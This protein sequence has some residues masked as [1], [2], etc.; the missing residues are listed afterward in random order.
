MTIDLYY[1]PASTPCRSVRMVAQGLG[2][3]LNLKLVDV[4]AGDHLKP[5]FSKV[6]YIE[7]CL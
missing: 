3:E 5:E 4:L 1:H 7:I 2:V 6:K